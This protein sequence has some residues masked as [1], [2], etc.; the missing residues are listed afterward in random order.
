[1]VGSVA[2]RADAVRQTI[3]VVRDTLA[4]FAANGPTQT[5]AG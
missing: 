3:Q 2:T 5:G 1:M 4:E